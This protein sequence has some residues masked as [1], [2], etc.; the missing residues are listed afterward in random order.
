M[1]ICLNQTIVIRNGMMVWKVVWIEYYLRLN[2]IS[3]RY[4][5]YIK[6][7]QWMCGKIKTTVFFILPASWSTDISLFYSADINLFLIV[8]GGI[9]AIYG[10]SSSK[11]TS[12]VSWRN[13]IVAVITCVLYG[14][15]KRKIKNRTLPTCRLFLQHLPSVRFSSIYIE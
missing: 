13:N 2:L 4:S 5:E 11:T 10:C 7:K 14:N 1:F 12:G 9:R 15:I 3:R 6:C 8:P